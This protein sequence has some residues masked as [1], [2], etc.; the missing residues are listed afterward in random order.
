MNNMTRHNET[1]LN[2]MDDV[3]IA[4]VSGGSTALSLD[5][6]LRMPVPPHR[7]W[8]DRPPIVEVKVIPRFGV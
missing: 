3:S 1:I 6:L 5:T 2:E 4:E 8:R 7:L